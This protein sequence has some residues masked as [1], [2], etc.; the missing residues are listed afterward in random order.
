MAHLQAFLGAPRGFKTR[1]P[2]F[3][4]LFV[5]GVEAFS[6][7]IFR[8]MQ[9]NFLA[10]CKIGRTGEEEMV[11]SHMLYVDDILLFCEANQ[12]QLVHLSRTLMW[13]EAISRLRINLSKNEIIQVGGTVEE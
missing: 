3:P 8:A 10:G 13:F 5:I 12:N 4:Y 11:I 1:G 7:P 2:L 9:G 6:C